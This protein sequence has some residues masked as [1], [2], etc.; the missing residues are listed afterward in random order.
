MRRRQA[1]RARAPRQ[2]VGGV[3]LTTAGI[4]RHVAKAIAAVL[5][6]LLALWCFAF[7]FGRS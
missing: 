7:T 3:E 2:F 5:L 6:A 1:A 4:L